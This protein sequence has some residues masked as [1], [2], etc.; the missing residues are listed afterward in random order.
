MRASSVLHE[1]ETLRR[2][3]VA[4]RC[5]AAP[6]V[7]RSARVAWIALV[8]ALVGCGADNGDRDGDS[9]SNGDEGGESI[10]TDGDGFPDYRDLDSDADGIPD[11]TEAGDAELGS[12]PVDSDG[13]GTPDYL[14]RDSDGD[15]ITDTDE[16]DGTFAVVDTDGDGAPDHLDLDSDA[17]GIPDA[18]EA[19]DAD[20]ATGPR[21]T[22]RDGVSNFRDLDSDGDCISD[23]IEAGAVPESPVDTDGDGAHDFVDA[24]SDADGI[25]DRDEDK[26]CDGMV[27]AGES[28]PT[29][30]DTDGDGTPDLVEVVAG[31]D[32]NDPGSNIP[33]GDFYFV[34]PYQTGGQGILDFSTTVQQADVFFS[35]DTTGSFQQEIDAIRAALATTIVPGISAVIPNAAFGVG[36]FE[37]FPVAPHGLAGDKPFELLQP[38]TT[39]V[40][41]VSAALTAL[42]PASG[43]LD[44]PESGY[45][46]LFQ[47]ATGAGMSDFAIAPFAPP[48]IGGVGFRSSSLPIIVQITDARSHLPGEYSFATHSEANAIAA[49]TTLGIRVVG[50]DSL[51]NVGTALDPRAQLEALA[52]A[53]SAIIPPNAAG[54]CAT[55]VGGALRSPVDVGGGV[56]RCPV[57]FDVQPDGSGL[58][59]LIVDAI[60]QLATLGTLDIST[61]TRGQLMGL[62]GEILPV[63]TTT[64]DFITSITPVAPPPAGATILGNVFLGVTPG[65]TVKFTL[66]AFNDFVLETTEDQ[67]FAIDIDVVGD[68]VTVLDIRRVFVI[69]PR[70]PVVIF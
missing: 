32:P 57:V 37:D 39:N 5:A 30:S 41:A 40:A 24:D 18:I 44:V 10:D 69:V 2:I 50:V 63:G 65:S 17:D 56:L 55:G 3:V 1:A 70:K 58:G 20:L 9:I 49:L 11:A 36:R 53:T 15:T 6:R 16:L 13:D 43:G 35:V 66:V 23:R 47:W 26:N 31:S 7:V 25:A 34:L 19:I 33:P 12:P 62:R 52:I 59:T 67:L 42:A 8:I 60:V 29:S 4:H 21:D 68:L 51:E 46:S 28:S 27:N 45:E 38:I 61:A 14:D 64:A 48:G 22:D 54:Q